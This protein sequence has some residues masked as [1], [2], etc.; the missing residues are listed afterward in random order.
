MYHYELFVEKL[1]SLDNMNTSN[2]L[3]LSVKQSISII[4]KNISELEKN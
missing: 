3:L 4:E 1:H 2:N